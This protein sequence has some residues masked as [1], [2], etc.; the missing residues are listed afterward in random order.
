MQRA[1]FAVSR[2]SLFSHCGGRFVGSGVPVSVKVHEL[3]SGV[4]TRGKN[5]ATKAGQQVEE[6]AGED[7]KVDASSMDEEH[8]SQ[9]HPHTR[10]AYRSLSR[11]SILQ[12][13]FP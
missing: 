2:T 9:M 5:M 3:P 6:A 13:K 7:P 10:K 8:E 1:L 12:D 11:N 4:A